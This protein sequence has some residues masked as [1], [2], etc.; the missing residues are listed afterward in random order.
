MCNKLSISLIRLS[1]SH[2]NWQGKES[3]QKLENRTMLQLSDLHPIVLDIF[4][5]LKLRQFWNAFT[6]VITKH[7]QFLVEMLTCF[8]LH[9]PIYKSSLPSIL[10][11]NSDH[12][13][14]CGQYLCSSRCLLPPLVIN[15][16][17]NTYRTSFYHHFTYF[18][19]MSEVKNNSMR[20]DSHF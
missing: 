3:K 1:D 7:E 6:S 20:N 13:A 2:R 15:A 9:F 16:E 8:C 14:N 12:S 19:I 11:M 10:V 18:S 5:S 17:K 4:K